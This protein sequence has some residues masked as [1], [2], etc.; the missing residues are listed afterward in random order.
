MSLEKFNFSGKVIIG[1][2]HSD[3]FSETIK[4]NQN[5]LK[6]YIASSV[7]SIG[8]SLGLKSSDF[9]IL[10]KNTLPCPY[11]INLKFLNNDKLTGSISRPNRLNIA[12][13]IIDSG[14]KFN[15]SFCEK[16]RSD[17]QSFPIRYL[18]KLLED[19]A[20]IGK[21]YLIFWDE[22]FGKSKNTDS[23]LNLLKELN[24]SF[25]CNTRLDS[26]NIEFITKLAIGNCKSILIGLEVGGNEN[27]AQNYLKIDYRKKKYLEKLESIISLLNEFNIDL[28]GSL[29]IGLPNDTEEIISN[30]ILHYSNLGL[31]KIYIRPLVVFP[32][33]AIYLESIAKN[34]IKPYEEW[35]NTE[36]QT[37]P[38]GY[39][40][41]CRNLNREDLS[42]WIKN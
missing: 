19:Y 31:K 33:S 15:C 12:Q 20:T 5:R 24:L 34:I 25:T 2:R 22:V 32:G 8:K 14:C 42:Q 9:L 3:F 23:I 16:A 40:T 39:P 37:Y 38:L 35:N 28:I 4:G 29:I 18:L 36:L 11:P 17:I 10:G 26:L 13:I 21:N 6:I 41:I 7:E 1:G 30:R 27:D